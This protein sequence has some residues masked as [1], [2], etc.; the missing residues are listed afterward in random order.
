MTLIVVIMIIIVVVVV[1]LQLKL[2]NQWFCRL[3]LE[4]VIQLYAVCSSAA[5]LLAKLEGLFAQYVRFIE[6]PWI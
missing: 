5:Y 6:G 3:L 1:Y 4:A 2:V